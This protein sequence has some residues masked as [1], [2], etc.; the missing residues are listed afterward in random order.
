M[1]QSKVALTFTNGGEVFN[2]RWPNAQIRRRLLEAA[3]ANRRSL[4]SEILYR[5]ERSLE[6]EGK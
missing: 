3:G 4:H 1:K 2:L 5:L 6:A